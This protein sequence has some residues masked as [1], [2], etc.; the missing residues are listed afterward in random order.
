MKVLLLTVAYPPM[1]NSA[2]RLFSDLAQGLA[3]EGHQVTVLTSVPDRY[4]AEQETRP[5]RRPY[6]REWR[7]GVRVHRVAG[8]PFA[9]HI[10]LLRGLE[11]FVI[12]YAYL[13][14]GLLLWRQQ[15]VI[16]YSPPLPLGMTGYLLARLWR[17]RV[18]INV[19]DLYPQTAIDLGLLRNPLLVAASRWMERFLYRHADVITV[20]STG[21]RDYVLAHGG[22][23]DRVEVV[24]NWVN[25]KDLRPG[26]KANKFRAVH[27]LGS[28]FVVSYAGVM[29]FAQGLEDVVAAARQL[30]EYPDILFLLVGDGVMRPELERQ[31]TE[32]GLYN[33]R[34]LPTQPPSVYLQLLAASDVGLATLRGELATPVVPGKVQSIMAAGRPVLCS[35]NP[36]SDAVRLVEEAECGRCVPAGH[37]DKLAEAI[38]TLYND[39]ALAEGMGRRGRAYAKAHFDPEHCIGQYERLLTQAS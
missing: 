7:D 18:I 22:R 6:Q 34:L 2:A 24:F 10:P 37:P 26:P 4:L 25:L 17:G 27:R 31:V 3:R 19:Q 16:V 15:A 36:R 29:G 32:Q 5:S 8:L 21:N 1:V 28:A 13:L 9:R 38:L 30:R 33:V 14:V 11:H 39:R 20:H 23:P 12:A 35:M